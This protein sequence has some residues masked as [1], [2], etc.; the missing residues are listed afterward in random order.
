MNNHA[1]DARSSRHGWAVEHT[2]AP[3][4]PSV[5]QGNKAPGLNDFSG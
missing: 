1:F 4:L 2:L 3:D 5:T